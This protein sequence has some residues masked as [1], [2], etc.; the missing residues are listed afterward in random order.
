VLQWELASDGRL[1]AVRV[2]GSSGDETLDRQALDMVREAISLP[3]MPAAL[4]GRPLTVDV[5][6][7]FRVALYNFERAQFPAQT[8]RRRLL[9]GSPRCRRGQRIDAYSSLSP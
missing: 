6:V 5:P 3:P 4:A 7:V 8:A 1:L 2:V 9:S